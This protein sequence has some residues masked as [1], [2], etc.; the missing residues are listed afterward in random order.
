MVPKFLFIHGVKYV[1]I[2]W[3]SNSCEKSTQLTYYTPICDFSLPRI[4]DKEASSFVLQK[5][6]TD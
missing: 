3:L 1:C 2:R 6:F 4:A 5:L